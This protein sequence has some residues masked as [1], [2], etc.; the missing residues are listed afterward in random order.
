MKKMILSVL[1]AML[2][3]GVAYADQK[4]FAAPH[5]DRGAT[6]HPFY[7]GYQ[8]KHITN[9]TEVLVCSA[10]CIL[11]DF[12]MST[13]A[14]GMEM[15][16]RDTGTADG[17]GTQALPLIKFASDCYAKLPILSRPLR[18]TYG[19]SVDFTGTAVGAEN[20]VTVVY[21]DLD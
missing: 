9:T 19:W 14:L 7:G 16:I 17:G 2:A 18:A 13:G 1:A 10:P 3:V 5:D 6:L 12:I 15:T 11:V 4:T 21:M 20:T 8:Y